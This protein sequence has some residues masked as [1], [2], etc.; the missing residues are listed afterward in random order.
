MYI[1]WDGELPVTPVEEIDDEP[2][3]C[4]GEEVPFDTAPFPKPAV[5]A[6]NLKLVAIDVPGTIFVS[7][8]MVVILILRLID[9]AIP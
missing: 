1:P 7:T 6:Q 5:T 9:F 3:I 8:V 4:W 2:R